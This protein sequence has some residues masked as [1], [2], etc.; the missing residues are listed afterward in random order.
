M[1][2]IWHLLFAIQLHALFFTTD[3]LKNTY[4]VT[5]KNQ[6]VKYDSTGVW[7][8]EF[9]VKAEGEVARID[10]TNPLKILVL[11]RNS[12]SIYFLDNTLSYITDINLSFIG[13]QNPS[14]ACNSGDGGFWVYDEAEM[15]MKKFDMKLKETEETV[16]LNSISSE[17]F[18]PEF[19]MEENQM[20]Y[21]SDSTQGILAFDM[22]GSFIYKIPLKGVKQ[23]QVVN[24]NIFYQKG[25]SLFTYLSKN[26]EERLIT[27]LPENSKLVRVAQ[28]CLWVMNENE[29]SVYPY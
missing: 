16:Q 3:N 19:M 22:F 23:F 14:V 11:Y 6:I 8:F 5:D 18:H 17:A 1:Q 9:Q 15:K 12:S 7:Q 10:A 27:V 25:N 2:P 20:L 21:V 24:G 13:I 28:H 29:I 26:F 4:V